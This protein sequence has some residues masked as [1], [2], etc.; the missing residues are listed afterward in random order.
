[1]IDEELAEIRA[2][3]DEAT[4]GPWFLAYATVHDR[5]RA[6]EFMR[7]ERETPDA[8]P[9][10]AYEKLPDTAICHVPVVA[11][12]TPT[13]QGAR[14]AKFIAVARTA[15]PRLLDEVAQLRDHVS[16]IP[17]LLDNINRLTKAVCEP[18]EFL[19]A[20]RVATSDENTQLR[21]ALAE[22]IDIFDATWCPEHGHAP[23]PEQL[24]RMSALRQ[25]VADE[26]K[27]IDEDRRRR[28]P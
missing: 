9:D 22:A 4:P 17:A 24:E 28:S 23:K 8:A 25:L 2:V 14:D 18:P 5:P 15:V 20:V 27:K 7:I 6:Q 13:A 10:A 12:D 26:V 1:M 11:G 19:E 16:H 3:S 21:A